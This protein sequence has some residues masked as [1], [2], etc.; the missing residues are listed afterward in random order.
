MTGR[1]Q[2]SMSRGH[3]QG[4]ADLIELDCRVNGRWQPF[5]SINLGSFR[6]EYREDLP[7]GERFEVTENGAARRRLNT[8]TDAVLE[9]NA[10]AP[11]MDIDLILTRMGR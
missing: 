4:L 9:V 1:T 8:L 6:I 3:A 11:D 2:S 10:L 7:H 5:K